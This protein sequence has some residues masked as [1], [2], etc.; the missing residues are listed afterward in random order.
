MDPLNFARPDAFLVFIP[1][2][3]VI[4]ALY[5]LRMRRRE[6]QVPA[7]FLWPTHTEEVRANTFFQ[8]LKP[9]WLL[10]LQ[11]LALAVIVGCIARPQLVQRGLTGEITVLVLDS[12]ASMGATDVAPSRFEE[13]KRLARAAIESARPGD[14]IAM[15]E[16]GPVP[17]VV[18]S[19]SS[20]PVRQLAD[21][22]SLQVT[23]A[24]TDVG[25]AM[26]L[27]SAIVSGTEGAR[28]VLLSDGVFERIDDFSQGK[29]S[30]VFQSIGKSGENLAI[31]AFGASE[32]QRGKLLFASVRN[33][34]DKAVTTNLTVFADGKVIDSAQITVSP[35]KSQSRTINVPAGSTLFEAKIDAKDGLAAD[36]YA[37]LSADPAASLQVLKVGG[38]D[39]FLDRAL[40]LDPRVTLDRADS[41]PLDGGSSYDIVVFDGVPAEPTTSRGVLILGKA[42]TGSPVTASGTAKR[43]RF[44]GATTNPLMQGVDLDGVYIEE[45]EVVQPKGSAEVLARSAAGP[46]IVADKKPSQRS[47]YLAF[48]PLESDFPLQI[49]FPIFVSNMLDFLGGRAGEGPLVVPVGRPFSL[50]AT[51]PTASLK[52][53]D[54]DDVRLKSNGGAVTIR[55]A[56]RVGTYSFRAGNAERKLIAVLQS[57]RESALAPEREIALAKKPVKSTDAPLRF[58]DFWQ[59]LVLLGLLVLSAEWWLYARRS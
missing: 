29:A 45:I 46:L 18:F 15:V 50:P 44:T 31:E 2:A 27:A 8:K 53:P 52:V 49:G 5:L 35:Q 39:P 11:L 1:L 4:I 24:E 16:A 28:I 40:A 7:T 48:S 56:K 20:D 22:Q 30:V 6:M 42:G 23:D 33:F 17:R 51:T 13:A 47:V 26:R 36:N 57:P 25:E 32:S 12:S 9:S 59:P 54:G 19:L 41:L 14:R 34:G 58:A 21:L 10:F 37:A 43:P 55:E 3:A 38:E